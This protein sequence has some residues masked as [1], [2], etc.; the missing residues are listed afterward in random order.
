MGGEE[1]ATPNRVTGPPLVPTARETFVCCDSV[2]FVA[3]DLRAG[4]GVCTV[5]GMGKGHGQRS[6]ARVGTRVN[7][8]G[9]PGSARTRAAL[10]RPD[11]RVVLQGGQYRFVQ[12]MPPDGSDARR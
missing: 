6:G 4:G 11:G 2:T 1:V 10:L 9:V 5:V 7:R 8:V 3:V 12:W